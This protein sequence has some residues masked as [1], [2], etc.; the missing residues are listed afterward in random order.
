MNQPTQQFDDQQKT[1]PGIKSCR[2]RFRNTIGKYII[3][4]SAKCIACG[5]CAEVCQYGV[6]V[7]PENHATPLRPIEHYCIGFGCKKTENYCIAHCPEDALTLKENPLLDTMGD[8]RWT[9]DMLLGHFAMAE[10]GEPPKVDIE[11]NLGNS[12]G[13]FD[14]MRFVTPNP[15]LK[16]D[17]SDQDIDTSI[18]LN[19]TGDNRP[20]KT[21]SIPCYGGGMSYGSTALS[22]I[23]GRARAA[24]K[25]N[26]LTCTGE[27]GYP[28]EFLPYKDHVITQV[29]TGLLVSEKKQS[30]IVLSWNLNMPRV[31][32]PD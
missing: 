16:I 32:N 23:V 24:Q 7:M 4:R 22:V 6:H 10:T 13:G 26:S 19:K 25:L 21:I 12:G 29:A 17:I 2:S 30:K 20:K 5:K 1:Q 8:Y 28:P 14:K 31:Q 18:E 15:D 9:P 3:K 27:G 11:Y